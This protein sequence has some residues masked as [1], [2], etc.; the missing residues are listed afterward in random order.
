ME[1][2]WATWGKY[3]GSPNR[4]HQK[5][6]HQAGIFLVEKYKKFG[7]SA[8][9]EN[10]TPQNDW[11]KCLDKE[12]RWLCGSKRARA[13]THK[14]SPTKIGWRQLHL[15]KKKLWHR[16][17]TNQ[18]MKLSSISDERKKEISQ[19][20]SKLKTWSD[21]ERLNKDAPKLI[22]ETLKKLQSFLSIW[23]VTKTSR[24]IPPSLVNQKKKII[25]EIKW[26]EDGRK[27]STAIESFLKSCEWSYCLLKFFL[28]FDFV[29]IVIDQMTSGFPPQKRRAQRTKGYSPFSNTI[30]TIFRQFYLLRK[31][32]F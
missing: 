24:K 20:G 28:L 27:I 9:F 4:L 15:R 26:R 7:P 22:S 16:H 6:L 13:T 12:Y 21:A 31:K 18:S 2:E 1:K 10:L 32:R 19:I 25:F 30:S 17:A 23:N 8:P 11:K 3:I 14:F 29:L 5:L